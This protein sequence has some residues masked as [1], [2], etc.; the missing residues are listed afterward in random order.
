MGLNRETELWTGVLWVWLLQP[1]GKNVVVLSERVHGW[2]HVNS[3]FLCDWIFSALFTDPAAVDAVLPELQLHPGSGQRVL[4]QRQKDQPHIPNLQEVHLV[5]ELS[6][7][8]LIFHTYCLFEIVGQPKVKSIIKL[9]A[10]DHLQVR[11]LF[12]RS[13]LLL[14]PRGNQL[15]EQVDINEQPDVDHGQ[16]SVELAMLFVR[17]DCY[18][19]ELEQKEGVGNHCEV[20]P[21]TPLDLV[22]WLSLETCHGLPVYHFHLGVLPSHRQTW[23]VSQVVNYWTVEKHQN[24]LKHVL[25]FNPFPGS[26]N[27]VQRVGY[28]EESILGIIDDTFPE[29]FRL[30]FLKGSCLHFAQ[31]DN[32]KV[33]K[34]VFGLRVQHYDVEYEVKVQTEEV[35]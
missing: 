28:F 24:H 31:V 7:Y 5:A 14:Q 30:K 1:A 21:T 19:Q 10:S 11:L 33:H 29:I 2:V 32:K 9:M 16:D 6:V 26:S 18:V 12:F 35:R 13:A 8:D 22:F 34:H 4:P 3:V 20:P 17:P 25:G 15:C 27:K 23:K